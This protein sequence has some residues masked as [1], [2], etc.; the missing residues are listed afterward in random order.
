MER[1]E[2]HTRAAASGNVPA[3]PWLEALATVNAAVEALVVAA[4][5]V[6][7]FDTLIRHVCEQAVHAVPHADVVS[8]TLLD[9]ETGPGTAAITDPRLL[10]LDLRQYDS[11]EG[12]C[13]H[14]A[15]TGESVRVAIAD[16]DEPWPAFAGAAR[17]AGVGSV[18]SVRLRPDRGAPGSVNCF[19]YAPEDFDDLDLVLLRTYVAAAEGVLRGVGRYLRSNQA[20]DQLT[21]ALT[22]RGV[23]EQ[24]KGVLMA[25]RGLGPDEAFAELVRR[26]QHQN[27]KL[28]VI[29][30]RVVTDPHQAS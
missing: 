20:V 17:S 15:R 18:L 11:D 8:V 14:A 22:S 4:A 10:D 9:D 21:A 1:R 30:R 28:G 19:G 29:A 23:I 12:P 13:L 27:T 3:E 5:D 2:Q 25:T 7:D 24:A 6:E 16:A 26:S